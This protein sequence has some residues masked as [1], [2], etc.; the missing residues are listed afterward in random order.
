MLEPLTTPR[1]IVDMMLF[2]I[3][4]V[5]AFFVLGRSLVAAHTVL[6]YPGWR[7]NN[8]L[9]RNATPG[10]AAYGYQWDYPCRCDELWMDS[11]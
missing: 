11:I 9:T 1:Q 3:W 2:G 7:G 4:S 8:L 5:V 6:S 10:D